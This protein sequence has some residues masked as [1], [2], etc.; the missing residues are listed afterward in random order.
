MV[1]PKRNQR[2]L[3]VATSARKL[4]ADRSFTHRLVGDGL[5]KPSSGVLPQASVV[6]VDRAV[7]RL[8]LLTAAQVSRRFKVTR[9][10]I[11][12][13]RRE[14]KL[15]AWEVRKSQFHY[16][17]WQFDSRGIPYKSVSRILKAL[18]G[19]NWAA[20]RFLNELIPEVGEVGHRAIA[21]G[22]DQEVLAALAARSLGA[23]S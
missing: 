18:D 23:F 13:W 14:G 12:R 22:R 8:G 16:P 17:S 1:K 6:K 20:L 11:D 19:D 3:A 10:A 15:I 4:P 21:Q 5:P 2:R 7:S 9:Q